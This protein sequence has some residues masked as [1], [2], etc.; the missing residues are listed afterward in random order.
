[1]W[2]VAAGEFKEREFPAQSPKLLA[3]D[4]L[5]TKDFLW[6]VLKGKLVSCS[7]WTKVGKT[8]LQ[9]E[10]YWLPNNPSWIHRFPSSKKHKLKLSGKGCYLKNW[11]RS[12]LESPIMWASLARGS[13]HTSPSYKAMK[14]LRQ[15]SL[16]QRVSQF[17]TCL[18][19]SIVC[20]IITRIRAQD[21]PSGQLQSQSEGRLFCSLMLG[22]GGEDILPKWYSGGARSSG[23]DEN[24]V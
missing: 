21:A 11:N 19:P 20:Q 17:F 23:K 13:G 4:Q 5:K 12:C 7:Y 14:T 2:V 10:S 22:E 15:F 3:K 6:S 16:L 9:V 24:L 1:M 18:I 8:K